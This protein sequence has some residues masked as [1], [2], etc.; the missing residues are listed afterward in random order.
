ELGLFERRGFTVSAQRGVEVADAEVVKKQLVTARHGRAYFFPFGGTVPVGC[1][2]DRAGVGGEA[3]ETA[4][5]ADP[6]A[7]Q[8]ADIEL[9]LLTHFRGPSVPEVGVVL[10]DHDSGRVEMLGQ[11]E[12]RL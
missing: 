8:L 5:V 3:D 4:V 12:E 7:Y 1:G 9:S 2:G 11:G 10:P 6:L